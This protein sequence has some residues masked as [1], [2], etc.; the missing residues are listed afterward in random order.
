MLG[1]VVVISIVSSGLTVAVV[2]VVVLG[3]VVG[4]VDGDPLWGRDFVVSGSSVSLW[5]PRVCTATGGRVVVVTEE[6]EAEAAVVVV[7]VV[8]VVG[9]SMI[10]SSGNAV[11]TTGARVGGGVP[12]RSDEASGVPA[13]TL[14]VSTVIAGDTD[15]PRAVGVFVT[16][17]RT[18]PTA[19]AAIV[20]AT[21]VATNQARPIPPSAFIPIVWC[22]FPDTATRRRTIGCSGLNGVLPT[23]Q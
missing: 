8:V 17:L 22:K 11:S 4:V 15:T 6:E 3:G 12:G 20:T 18:L 23:C 16:S 14:G 10:G 13:G 9:V 1:A 21:T 2:V 7:V 19:T 5:A